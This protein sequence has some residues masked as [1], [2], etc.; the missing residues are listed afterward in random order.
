M[1]STKDSFLTNRARPAPPRSSKAWLSSPA[2][3]KIVASFSRFRS[4]SL[5]FRTLL[6]SLVTAKVVFIRP[7]NLSVHRPFSIDFAYLSL[8]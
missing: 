3:G 4:V 8:T 2:D 1:Q 7:L 6:R 5:D